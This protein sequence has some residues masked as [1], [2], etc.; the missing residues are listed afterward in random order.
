MVA[1]CNG[2]HHS[3]KVRTSDSEA[4]AYRRYTGI[5][6][7]ACGAGS[8]RRLRTAFP[9]TGTGKLGCEVLLGSG[10]GSSVCTENH[11]TISLTLPRLGQ[12]HCV[13]PALYSLVPPVGPESFGTARAVLLGHP[14]AHN[15]TA[16]QGN[17]QRQ[18]RHDPG[19]AGALSSQRGEGT[20]L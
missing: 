4:I 16:R 18:R 2:W 1:S 3:L 7:Q 6:V 20:C 17:S 12:Q 15:V 8:R 9:S 13:L 5:P 11:K 10:S 14:R 19:A